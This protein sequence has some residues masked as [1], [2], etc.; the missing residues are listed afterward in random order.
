MLLLAG[1]RRRLLVGVETMGAVFWIL[2]Y[3]VE[4][5][6]GSVV[7]WHSSCWSDGCS[8]LW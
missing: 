2:F 3:G 1:R 7:Y 6:A 5:F 4:T 8:L